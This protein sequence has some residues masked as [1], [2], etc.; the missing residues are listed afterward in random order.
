MAESLTIRKIIERVISGEIRIPAFQRDWVWTPQQV[1]FLLDSIYKNFPIGTVFLWKTTTRLE[2]EKDLGNFM[3]PEPRK[4]H[5]VYYV[6]DGQQRI[7]SLFSA[8]QTELMPSNNYEWLDIYFDFDACD[9]IQESKFVALASADVVISKHFPVGVMFDAGK[10]YAEVSKLDQGKRD[11]ILKV[12]QM[13]Q[14]YTLPVQE[15]ETDSKESIAIVFERINR[16]G[17][18]LNTYQLLTAWSWS[19]DFD[20]QEEFYELSEELKPYGFGNL[21]LDK[22]LQLKCCSGIIKGETSP[23]VIM[24]LTGEDVRINFPKIKN[25][26]KGAIEFLKDQL[27]VNSLE[28]LPYPSMIVSLSA[29][30]ATDKVGGMTYN[31][32]QRKQLIKWF[33]KS[34]FSRRYNAAIQDKHRQDIALMKSLSLDDTVLIAEFYCKLEPQ[35]FSDSLFNVGSVNTKTFVLMLAS[36]KPRSFISGAYVRLGDV[37][38]TVNRNEFHHIFP[39]KHLERLG[40]DKRKIN[41]LANFCFLN[42]ADNQKIKDKDPKKYKVLL[43]KTSMENILESAICPTDGL[44]KNFDDFITDRIRNLIK[45]ASILTK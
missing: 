27:N 43:P 33:W 15:F 14:E 1:S 10:F 7:T 23:S 22:D 29:F 32:N 3:I 6:L 2:S 28:W 11:V 41:C 13:F 31:D 36:N 26:I 25:G 18:P 38:K 17:T 45:Y 8:F 42:N 20:L 30:F 34:N 37:L 12:Q 40:V 39:K 19:S 24:N 4:E 35:Y 16:A 9:D 21:A 5:P 44:E